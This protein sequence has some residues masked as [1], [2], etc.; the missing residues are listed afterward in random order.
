MTS[1]VTGE[2]KGCCRQ[3]SRLFLMPFPVRLRGVPGAASHGFRQAKRSGP[4]RIG[5]RDPRS[6]PLPLRPA[7]SQSVQR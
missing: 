2:S 1:A 3:W 4:P 6:C 7:G 5:S